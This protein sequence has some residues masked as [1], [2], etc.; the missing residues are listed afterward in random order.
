MLSLIYYVSHR[1]Y[2][3]NFTGKII[4]IMCFFL[5]NC[6]GV[7]LRENKIMVTLSIYIVFCMSGKNKHCR[8]KYPSCAFEVIFYTQKFD[9]KYSNELITHHYIVHNILFEGAFYVLVL[10][11]ARAWFVVMSLRL[12]SLGKTHSINIHF[13]LT[14]NR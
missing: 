2:C 7:S 9:F 11:Y 4:K 8:D 10:I 14:Y 5:L 1:L 3:G 12:T 13:L 6:A